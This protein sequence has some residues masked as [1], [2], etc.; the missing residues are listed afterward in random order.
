MRHGVRLDEC[1]EGVRE[2][3]FNLLK[4]TMSP[5]GFEKAMLATET[6]HFLGVLYKGPGVLNRYSYNFSLFGEPS[7]TEPWGFYFFGHHLCLSFFIY[8]RH[9]EITP[10]FM[11]AEPN[12]IDEGPLA[13]VELYVKEQELGRQLMRSLPADLQ[14]QA[15][16]SDTLGHPPGWKGPP[17]YALGGA[18]EDNRVIPYE[19]T[20]MKTADASLK[21]ILLQLVEQFILYLPAPARQR[22]LKEVEKHIDITYFAWVGG[23]GEDDKFYFRIHSPVILCE[24]EHCE[25]I[26]LGNRTPE[27]FHIHTHVRT[28]NAGD[29]G[30]ALL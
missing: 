6:N 8:S 22:K 17:T 23:W 26:F 12:Q 21:S 25:S 18:M 24:F 28:P 30:M 9:I 1:N 11:G 2:S 10:T 14:K 15:L 20:L 13:G 19:G 5:E 29:Y 16:L 4:A 3:I 27:K 7:T